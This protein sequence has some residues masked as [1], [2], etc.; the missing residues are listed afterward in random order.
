MVAGWIDSVAPA[1]IR[2]P[3]ALDEPAFLAACERCDKCRVACPADA[4]FPMATGLGVGTPVIDPTRTPCH[5]C[6]DLPCIQ[7]CPS[8]A[9]VPVERL[10]VR[11]ATLTLKQAACLPFQGTPCE[12]CLSACPVPGALVQDE[13]R[14]VLHA[15]RCTGCG[16]CVFS[17]P[18]AAWVANP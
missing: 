6:E 12:L 4:I 8:G 2:P 16:C 17:C 9:L 14:P 13:G 15:D 5:L 10:E 18:T 1:Q 7:A 11:M 3:G